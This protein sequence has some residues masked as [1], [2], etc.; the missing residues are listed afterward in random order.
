MNIQEAIIKSAIYTDDTL[1]ARIIASLVTGMMDICDNC[2]FTMTPGTMCE[3]CENEWA[4]QEFAK[5]EE[6]NWGRH[7]MLAGKF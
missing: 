5:Q 6:L 1:R 7:D 4:D 3:I 2:G